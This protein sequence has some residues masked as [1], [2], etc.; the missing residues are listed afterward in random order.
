MKNR[1]IHILFNDTV[2]L[3]NDT[4][5]SIEDTMLSLIKEDKTITITDISKQLKM[6]ISTIKRKIKQLKEQ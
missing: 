4:V 5:K 2:K 1:E 6:S 3:K